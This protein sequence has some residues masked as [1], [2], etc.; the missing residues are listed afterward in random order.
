MPSASVSFPIVFLFIALG[1]VIGFLFY[2]LAKRQIKVRIE[3]MPSLA[4]YYIPELLNKKW[5]LPVWEIAFAGFYTASYL[6]L[7]ENVV[8]LI[9]AVIFISCSINIIFIDL[10]IRRI[11]NELLVIMLIASLARFIAEPLI[12][13][14]GTVKQNFTLAVIGIICGFVLFSLPQKLG[15]YIGAGDI[16]LSAVIGFSLGLVGYLQAMIIMALIMLVY[17]VILLITK[18]GNMKSFA[19]MGPALCVGSIISLL[20]PILSNNIYIL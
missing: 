15:K 7:S 8:A 2:I 1:L 4:E 3:K 16:K 9:Y 18:K 14:E 19:P 6:L 13:E 10:A 20:F 17:L 5:V 12:Y 11:P